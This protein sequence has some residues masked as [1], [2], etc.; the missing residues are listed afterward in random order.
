MIEDSLKHDKLVKIKG[1]GTFKLIDVDS[2]ESI[3]INTGERFVIEG[4]TKISFTPESALRELINKPFAHFETVALNENTVLEDTIIEKEESENIVNTENSNIYNQ[5]TPQI[6]E[7]IINNDITEVIAEP[8]IINSTD[9]ETSSSNDEN[10]N[11]SFKDNI[12]PEEDNSLESKYDL[13]DPDD[14]VEDTSST[15]SSRCVKYII[16][17]IIIALLFCGGRSEERRVG[18]EC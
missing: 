13:N 3:N 6:N 15:V 12:T 8:S 11:I 18:K 10:H 7:D 5:D 1:L 17:T 2:R 9:S 14:I 4:Y 16:I